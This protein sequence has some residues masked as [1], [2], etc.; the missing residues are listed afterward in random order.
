MIRLLLF[1]ISLLTAPS[2]AQPLNH[3]IHSNFPANRWEDAMLSGNGLSGVMQYGGQPKETLIFN[4]H[5]FLNPGNGRDP[6]PD[7]SDMLEPMRREMLAGRIGE[8]WK[9]YWDEWQKRTNGGMFWTQKFHPGYRLNLEFIGGSYPIK[10]KRTTRYQTGEII[11]EFTDGFGDWKR[12]TFVS[13]AHDIIVT[14]LT[15]SSKGHPINLTLGLEACERHPKNISHEVLVDKEWLSWRAKYPA[16]NGEQGGYEGVT[17]I[18]LPKKGRLRAEKRQKIKITGA[19]EVILIT[20]LDRHRADFKEWDKLA[21][22]KKLAAISPNYDE[23][24]R[25]HREIHQPIYDR[26]HY[27]LHASEE[28]RKQSTE[29]LIATENADKNTIHPALLERL[30]YTSRY[31]FMASSGAEYAPRLSGV[32]LGR[33]GAAWAGDYTMDANANMAV[34]GGHIANMSE[35]MRGYQALIERTL[36]QWR[37]GAK[38]LYG[39]R[40][41][42]GPVRIDG[43]V[44][45]PHHFNHYHAHPTATGLGPWI[46]YPLW[47]KYEIDGDKEFLRKTL[48]PIMKEILLFYEDFLTYKDDNGK[49]IFVPSCSPENGWAKIQPRTSAAIN[50]TMDISACRQLLTN[51]LKAEKDLGLPPSKSAQDLLAALPPYLVNKAG[52]LQEWAWPGHGE[53]YGHRHS[54]HMYVVWPGY[55]INP[56]NPKTKHLV[57]HVIKALEKKNHRIVQ[58]H[59]FIQRAIGWLRVKKPEPF[60]DILKYTLENNYLFASL[61]TSH[62]LNHRIYNFDYILSLQGMLIENAVFT[63][64][65][66]IELLP[67]MPKALPKGEFTGLKGR[68]RCTI[69]RVAWDLTKKNAQL[70]LTSD[71][72]QTLT[73]IIRPNIKKELTLKAGETRKFDFN[74]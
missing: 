51:L 26:V 64:P 48:Y 2:W 31:L 70:T 12:E 28:D 3:Q 15:K 67:A 57:P 7:M 18:I 52:A 25:Q 34:M 16:R 17:R 55:D 68:N 59:D 69:D 1:F 13:R 61:A 29:Q 20:A 74:F 72:D 8:G 46:I 4:S 42:L 24:L 39:M 47:E 6:I 32:F 36:P 49:L 35:C 60:Y 63:Q 30:F 22:K 40:G 44:A 45:V 71:I 38:Q 27:S 62:D 65:G 33:W 43:E 23:L 41:I 73:L 9:L 10:Y 50:S 66:L 14:R 21:L 19:P 53:N 37:D 58:A 11:T 5:K 54:S 56:E